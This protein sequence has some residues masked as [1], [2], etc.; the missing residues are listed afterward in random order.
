MTEQL[1]ILSGKSEEPLNLLEKGKIIAPFKHYQRYLV[2][3]DARLREEEKVYLYKA[4]ID[5]ALL[6]ARPFKA[7]E[8]LV[9]DMDSTLI[10]VECVDQ[11]AKKIGKNKE[12]ERITIKAMQGDL[13]FSQSL[14]ERVALLAGVKIK[15]IEEILAESIQLSPGAE[16]LL[17]AC[18]E[19]GIAFLLLSGGFTL[20]TDFLQKRYPISASAAN[21]LEIKDNTLTGRLLGPILDAQG[22]KEFLINYALKKGVDLENTVAVGDGANDIPMLKTA[23]IGY[24]YHAKPIVRQEADICID[25]SSLDFIRASFL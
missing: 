12:V 18:R 1:L 21:T 7:L 11:I 10:T 24:A 6:K 16:T 17:H 5:W 4:K 25:F 14:K 20:F 22:K 23:G 19:N 2:E 8:A 9:S 15:V 13:D 3:G